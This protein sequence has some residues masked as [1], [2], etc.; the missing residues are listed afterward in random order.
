LFKLAVFYLY[1]HRIRPS[2]ERDPRSHT[3]AALAPIGHEQLIPK[4]SR[5]DKTVA[6]TAAWTLLDQEG[7]KELFRR[8]RLRTFQRWRG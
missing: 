8:W 4:V 6:G 2:V 5:R 3:D 7:V 1:L